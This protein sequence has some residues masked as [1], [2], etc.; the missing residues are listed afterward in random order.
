MVHAVGLRLV[1]GLDP[2]LEVAASHA[3][4]LHGLG[5]R[6]SD[7][8]GG[9]PAGLSEFRGSGIEGRAGLLFARLQGLNGLIAVFQGIQFRLQFIEQARQGLGVDPVLARQAQVFADASIQL[10]EAFR[11]QL[12]AVGQAA[13]VVAGLID[14]DAG[15]F[16]QLDRRTD[17]FVVLRGVLQGVQDLAQLRVQPAVL[18]DLLAGGLEGGEYLGA[19][20]ELVLFGQQSGVFVLYRGQLGQFSA[21]EAQQGF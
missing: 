4:F 1:G 15:G 19:V 10:G 21:L 6:L 16:Q 11:V 13:Q 8:A 5:D 20:G 14:L 2:D 7:A 18:L 3:Q 9:L 17:P 12:D